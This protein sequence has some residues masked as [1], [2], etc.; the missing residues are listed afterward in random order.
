MWAWLVNKIQGVRRVDSAI[1]TARV[2]YDRYYIL[3]P[4]F[5]DEEERKLWTRGL[6]DFV[7]RHMATIGFSADDAGNGDGLHRRVVYAVQP[8]RIGTGLTKKW[9]DL[10]YPGVTFIP[11]D[12]TSPQD[13]IERFWKGA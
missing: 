5:P 9:F 11:T 10:H 4:Q 2:A 7:G 8:D 12:A 3:L 13:F 1:I 6:A